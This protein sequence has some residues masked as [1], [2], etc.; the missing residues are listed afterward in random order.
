[1]RPAESASR[2]IGTSTARTNSTVNV[3]QVRI[4]APPKAN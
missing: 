4:T 1:M 2:L 3:S